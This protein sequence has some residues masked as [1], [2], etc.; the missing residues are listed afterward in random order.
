LHPK[1]GWVIAPKGRVGEH[2]R[3]D[4]VDVDE[5]LRSNRVDEHPRSYMIFSLFD[6][7]ALKTWWMSII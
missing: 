5:N 6:Y 1:A 2:L 3:L 4:R 7:I